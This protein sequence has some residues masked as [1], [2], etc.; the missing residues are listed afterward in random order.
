[1]SAKILKFTP[2]EVANDRNMLQVLFLNRFELYAMTLRQAADDAKQEWHK[3]RRWFRSN[4][5]DTGSF[6]WLCEQIDIDPAVVRD[7]LG[8]R[9]SELADDDE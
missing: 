9:V 5:T 1:M 6:L 2:E 3:N 8:L 7:R 4:S